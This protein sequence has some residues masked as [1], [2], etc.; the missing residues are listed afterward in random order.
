M[1]PKA[2]FLRP[3]LWV[4]LWFRHPGNVTVWI[5]ACSKNGWQ[6]VAA[7]GLRQRDS[8]SFPVIPLSVWLGQCVC[9]PG[10][11]LQELIKCQ[12]KTMEHGLQHIIK[13]EIKALVLESTTCLCL[14][15][16]GRIEYWV[17]SN[18]CS[19]D[20]LWDANGSG[21]VQSFMVRKPHWSRGDAPE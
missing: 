3:K 11:N 6:H 15:Y 16:L 9:K 5:F 10:H 14:S 4:W 20:C 21:S 2:K 19:S 8:P 17:S 13:M 18:V 1:Q 12:N 7:Q